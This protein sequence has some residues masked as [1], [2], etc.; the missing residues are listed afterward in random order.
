MA[1]AIKYSLYQ[2]NR[3]MIGRIVNLHNK[4][5]K[6]QQN[7]QYYATFLNKKNHPLYIALS[8]RDKILGFVAARPDWKASKMTM[9][10]LGVGS[11]G[12]S[13][14]NALI[15]RVISD[16]KRGGFKTLT[17]TVRASS[18]DTIKY[19]KGLGFDAVIA[20]EYKD[21]EE[22]ITL[23]WTNPE[24]EDIL[25][26]PYKQIFKIR[27]LPEKQ[28]KKGVFK[29]RK[30]TSKDISAILSMHNE[31]LQKK[32]DYS[33]F[34]SKINLQYGVF[35]VAEDSEGQVAGYIVCRPETKPTLDRKPRILNFIS[36][37]VGN[38]YRKWGIGQALVDGMIQEARKIPN[39]EYI[40]GHVRE[41]NVG[42]I[43]LYKR[44]GFKLKTVG[45]YKDTEE[46]KYELF[47]RIRPPS[48]EPYWNKYKEPIL[49]TGF[50]LTLHE[51]VHALRDY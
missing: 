29:I 37:G 35:L 39:I 9:A 26:D 20:G 16:V 31:F 13:I 45:K 14:A 4:M 21:G 1:E 46:I 43:R 19:C 24:G 50:G 10:S 27:K 15:K 18:K 30:A 47:K 51:I 2:P 5:F 23:T 41:S 7:Y 36:L 25:K 28:P 22:K 49:W 38:Q 44:T 12:K 17:M 48:L 33:Y 40:Y 11:R 3:A 6:S 34:S 8:E 42:A 32:R